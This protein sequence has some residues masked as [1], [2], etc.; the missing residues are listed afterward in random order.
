M[1]LYR[2]AACLLNGFSE[3]GVADLKRE[4]V[5]HYFS[6]ECV[7]V[8]PLEALP[9]CLYQLHQRFYGTCNAHSSDCMH[10]QMA[11]SADELEASW[12]SQ[13]EIAAYIFALCKSSLDA[14]CDV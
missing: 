6:F 4:Q 10:A 1:A 12:Y 14:A 11:A 8:L 5:L 13:P 2:E 3:L 9:T 7:A